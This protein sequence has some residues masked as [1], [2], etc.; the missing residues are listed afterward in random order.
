M[1]Y[2]VVLYT[3]DFT[4]SLSR[5]KHARNEDVEKIIGSVGVFCVVLIDVN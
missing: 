2:N 4:L 3:R 1:K 5:V